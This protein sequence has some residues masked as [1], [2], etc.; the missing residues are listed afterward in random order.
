MI[1]T[2]DIEK[3]ILCVASFP[4][5]RFL[6]II[7]EVGFGCDCCG[8]CCTS[9]FNDHVFL[10][11]DDAA[12]I[13]EALGS[14]FLR[15]APYFDFCDELGRFYVMGYALKNKPRGDCIFYTG[16]RCKHYEIRPEICKIYPYMLH[17]E[18]DEEGNVDFRQVSGLNQHGLYHNDISD[19][20]CK[21]IAREVKKYEL[22]FLGQKLRFMHSIK[23]FFRK[24]NLRNS[25]Q[26]YDRMMRKYENGG[27]IEVYVF[28][29]GKLEKEIISKQIISS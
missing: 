14:G 17:R 2:E 5:E 8:K 12:R 3:E 26:M 7:R 11:D 6:D 13:I 19:E 24:Q 27:D 28:F 15:P 4:D 1:K 9:G 22:D 23:D 10:L 21:E 25:R 16:V 29:K 18:A 20:T